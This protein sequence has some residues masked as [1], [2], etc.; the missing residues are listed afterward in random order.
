VLK[1]TVHRDKAREYMTR[2]TALITTLAMN[3]LYT[4]KFFD[5]D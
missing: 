2:L 3:F 1:L 5:V 4:D